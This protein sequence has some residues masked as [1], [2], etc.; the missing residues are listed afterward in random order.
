M[1]RSTDDT[2]DLGKEDAANVREIA[3]ML[4]LKDDLRIRSACYAMLPPIDL[5]KDHPAV[6][7]LQRIQA[8]IAYCYS[9]PRHTFGDIFFH[10]EHA[11]LAIFSPQS[12][13]TF[14]VRP[15]HHVSP[16]GELPALEADEQHWVRGYEG[17][18]NFRNPFWVVKGSRLYPPVPHIFMN[19]SQSL[20]SDLGRAF[21]EAPQHHLLPML[22]EE[23]TSDNIR[24]AMTAIQWYNRAGKLAKNGLFDRPRAS[25]GRHLANFPKRLATWLC[26]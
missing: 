17:R 9:A 11:S 20:A 1:F 7:E 21:A 6:L 3:D 10:F 8:I 2:F 13:T 19:D 25:W 18:Y 15:D 12:V 24:R 5:D 14:L 26:F 16:A 22:I 4:F 23:H